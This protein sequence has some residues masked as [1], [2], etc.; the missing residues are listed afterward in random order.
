M[1][2]RIRNVPGGFRKDLFLNP[3][4]KR[5]IPVLLL[6][7]EFINPENGI[8]LNNTPLKVLLPS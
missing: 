8:K 6:S 3:A 2:I 5:H 1:V 4:K 7:L